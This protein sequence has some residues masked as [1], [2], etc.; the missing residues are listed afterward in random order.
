MKLY[1]GQLFGRV[2]SCVVENNRGQFRSGTAHFDDN[3][4]LVE[5]KIVTKTGTLAL[6][7]EAITN[8]SRV[9]QDIENLLDN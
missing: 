4:N 2:A 8:W 3:L 1:L 9:K 6:L 5:V 7:P